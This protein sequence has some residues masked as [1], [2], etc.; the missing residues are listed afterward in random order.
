MNS[1]LSCFLVSLYGYDR[2]G[3]NE[4]SEGWGP[5]LWP[6]KIRA[7]V[8]DPDYDG[9]WQKMF[10]LSLTWVIVLFVMTNLSDLPSVEIV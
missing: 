5:L 1:Y 7:L 9:S 3:A 10:N 4:S 6:T 2:C 8:W